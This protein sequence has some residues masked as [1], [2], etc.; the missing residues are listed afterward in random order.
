MAVVRS[1]RPHAVNLGINGHG[2]LTI[3]A[4]LK[5]YGP[6]LRPRLVLWFYYE[7]NDLRDL[8]G[9]KK[10]SPLLMKYLTPSFSQHLFERQPEIDRSLRNYLDAAMTKATGPVSFRQAV[11]SFYERRP[12]K[13]GCRP[14]C[15]GIFVTLVHR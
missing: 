4:T 14:S 9:W 3:L 2:P 12:T 10:N 5:D 15:W 6:G 13:Q 1:Q 11:Q 7:G 8:D